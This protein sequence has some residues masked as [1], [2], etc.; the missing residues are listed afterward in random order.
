M[1]KK[2]YYNKNCPAIYKIKNVINN[3]FYIGSSKKVNTRLI[4]H[5]SSLAKNTHRNKH[6][7]SS[8]NKY[9]KDNFKFEILE[10]CDLK[11]LLNK[12]QYYLDTLKP[13][14]NILELAGSPIGYKHSENFKTNASNRMKILRNTD[15][16]KNSNTFA[17]KVTDEIRNNIINDIKNYRNFKEILKDY[18][19]KSTSLYTVINKNFSKEEIVKYRKINNKKSIENSSRLRSKIEDQNIIFKLKDSGLSVIK[20]AKQLNVHRDT[21]YK[22]LNK[23][24]NEL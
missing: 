15:V 3:K 17:I 21:I 4:N 5:F 18:N 10:E 13:E 14:Y 6:L 22:I 8:Y 16:Y 11:D 7:Q 1:P 20:I 12:E 23:T 2:L 19:I 9:G 24:K